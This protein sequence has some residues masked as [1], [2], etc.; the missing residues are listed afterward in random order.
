M[1]SLASGKW[2]QWQQ[3]QLKVES[4]LAELI[5]ASVSLLRQSKRTGLVLVSAL[6]GA[7]GAGEEQDERHTGGERVGSI[8]STSAPLGAS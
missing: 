6:L 5:Q 8:A 1:D 4:S 2:Q 3:W 7:R